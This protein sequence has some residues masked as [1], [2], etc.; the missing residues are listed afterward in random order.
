MP[1]LWETRNE[2]GSS[3]PSIHGATGADNQRIIDDLEGFMSAAHL[4][5]EPRLARVYVYVCYYG[6]TTIADI[7]ETLDLKRATTYDDIETLERMGVIERETDQRPHQLSAN[8]FAYVEQDSFAVTPTVLHAIAR[9]E[10]DEDVEYFYNRYGRAALV[11][12]VHAAGLHYAGQL[13]KRMTAREL[14]IQPV[15]GI[16]IVDALAPVLA[17][18]REFDPYFSS[19][20]PET[21]DEIDPN[22][23]V[24]EP[25]PTRRDPEV[26][27]D[28]NNDG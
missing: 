13:T 21:A 8:P 20:F 4:L 15:E 2:E 16:A 18:G 23:D 25:A 1:A 9:I 22:V 28:A 5:E 11:G 19:L 27:E 24:A 26:P 10:F 12:A 17:A 3:T 14:D 7:I 6:P